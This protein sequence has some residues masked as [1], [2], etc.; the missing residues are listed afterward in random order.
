MKG[1]NSLAIMVALHSVTSDP[2]YLH[3]PTYALRA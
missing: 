1:S 3:L 2:V